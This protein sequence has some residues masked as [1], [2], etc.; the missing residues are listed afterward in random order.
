MAEGVHEEIRQEHQHRHE[1]RERSAGGERY[2][3]T[4]LRQRYAGEKDD[5]AEV[6][7]DEMH[8]HQATLGE[9]REGTV[10]ETEQRHGR[11]ADQIDM[12]VQMRLLEALVDANPDAEAEAENPIKQP[13]QNEPAV[14][15]FIKSSP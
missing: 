14:D 7:E 13:D 6:V 1:H 4:R 8:R 5:G 9:R 3:L 11:K 10:E 2:G 12:G 15:V